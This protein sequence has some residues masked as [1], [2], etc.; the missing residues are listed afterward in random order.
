MHAESFL[1]RNLLDLIIRGEKTDRVQRVAIFSMQSLCNSTDG[2]SF[3]DSVADLHMLP[4][5]IMA[6]IMY[7]GPPYFL[8]MLSV[9]LRVFV[10][11]SIV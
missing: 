3:F 7:G 6:Y 10:T 8:K 11:V 9:S 4:A 1:N 5:P 2:E